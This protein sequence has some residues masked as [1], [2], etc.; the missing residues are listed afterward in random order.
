[1]LRFSKFCCTVVAATALACAAQTTPPPSPAAH[2]GP[3][4]MNLDDL[5]RLLA[6]GDPHV[7]PDG[8]WVVYTVGTVDTTADKRISDLWM[9]SWDGTQDIRLTYGTDKSAS[10]PRW[11]PD[12]KYI[13]FLS[14]RPGAP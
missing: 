12:G 6:V 4:P 10:S 3:H 14:D 11:S 1:M 2:P 8:K 9:V 7:S 5:D 13:S